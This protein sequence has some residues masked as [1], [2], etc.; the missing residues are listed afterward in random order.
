MNRPER[1]VT[2]TDVTSI[3]LPSNFAYP[4][5]I[6]AAPDGTLYVGSVT[7]GNIL[8]VASDGAIATIFEETDEVFAGT[9]ARFDPLTNL[10]W[11]TSPDFLG[12]EID[13]EIIRRPHRIAAIELSNNTVAWSSN[14]PN[15]GFANDI[16]LDGE[17][18][19][20]ITDS[21]RDRILHLAG[22]GESFETVAADPLMTPGDL[23]PAGIAIAPNGDLIIG[24]YSDG[25]LLRVS[26]G[27][28]ETLAQVTP[29]NVSRPIENPDGLAFTPDGRLLILEGAADSGDGKLLAVDLSSPQPH[30]IDVIL[31]GLDSPL[32]LT[33]TDDKIAITEGR[34]RHLLVDDPSLTAPE[35]FRII[36]VPLPDLE[37]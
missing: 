11:V 3:E 1:D 12:Q 25:A 7:S 2:Y 5:G 32:N 9:S 6:T 4:N 37:G 36:T 15:E 33:L 28:N 30:N 10:L 13:G 8:R 18:G 26:L 24:L 29:I 21:L 22:P 35:T 23:G 17:G 19:I 20:Y 27:T 14:V 16:A 31:D 34:I